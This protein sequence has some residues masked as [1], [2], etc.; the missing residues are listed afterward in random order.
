MV[1]SACAADVNAD[2]DVELMAAADTADGAAWWDI[3]SFANY[4][5][6]RDGLRALSPPENP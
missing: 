5:Y 4:A 2:G 3:G 6:T 1:V